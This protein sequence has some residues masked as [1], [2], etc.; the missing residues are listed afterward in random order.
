MGCPFG[1]TT[2]QP[3]FPSNPPPPPNLPAFSTK[4]K[5][6]MSKKQASW[7][8]GAGFGRGSGFSRQKLAGNE[9]WN[10]PYKPSNWWFP[11]RGL[12][13]FPPSLPIAPARKADRFQ[14]RQA[15][16][17]ETLAGGSACDGQQLL[18]PGCLRGSCRVQPGGG[19]LRPFEEPAIMLYD[20]LLLLG[21]IF[22]L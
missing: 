18:V 14:L 12:G 16:R 3:P 6:T 20:T 22:R 19:F 15:E 4:S 1:T 13:S 11:L 10:D 7:D 8:P 21:W 5:I 2:N 17:L 9:K